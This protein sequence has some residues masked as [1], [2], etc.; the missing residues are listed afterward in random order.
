MG[1]KAG[2]SNNAKLKH[3][4]ILSN[5]IDNFK[6]KIYELVMQEFRKCL[7]MT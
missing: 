2:I 5:K 7:G 1:E 4:Q 6:Y 3:C